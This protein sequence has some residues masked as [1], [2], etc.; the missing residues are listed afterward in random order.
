MKQ[1]TR[2]VPTI[3]GPLHIG[4]L[5]M[6][7][8]NAEEAHRSGGKFV[9]RVDDTQRYWKHNVDQR[10]VDQYYNQYCEELSRFV[11]VDTFER[12]SNMPTIRDIIGEQEFLKFIP[13]EKWIYPQIAEW[14][15]SS[16][17]GLYPCAPPLTIEKVVWDFY[18]NTTWLIRGED[19]IT[20]AS[21]YSYF[22]ECIGIPQVRQT[23]LPRLRTG[24]QGELGHS[25][26]S[27]TYKTYILSAQ[28]DALGISGVIKNLSESCLIDSI[29]KFCV[30]NVKPN[31]TVEG[32]NV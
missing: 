21:L 31:P 24:V 3:T 15:P 11:T 4:H 12:Q 28:I 13:K 20:E 7:L 19:L 29:G 10:L 16:E 23:Y 26:I 17:M 6:A 18:D 1:N 22:A 2:F 14:T 25:I 8:V 9:V 5:Y 32:F 27:K 30:D